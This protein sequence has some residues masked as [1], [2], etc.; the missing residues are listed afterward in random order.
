MCND[1]NM[2]MNL[3]DRM[4]RI[5]GFDLLFDYLYNNI[6]DLM[7]CNHNLFDLGM[8]RRLKQS[9]IP[10]SVVLDWSEMKIERYK[11]KIARLM[12]DT[13]SISFNFHLTIQI[14]KINVSQ[15]R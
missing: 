10:L 15:F 2:N 4:I 8:A 12:I 11:N 7:R 5:C 6:F 1:I 9:M 14:S 13:R 3:F